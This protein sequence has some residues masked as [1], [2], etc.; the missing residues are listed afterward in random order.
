MQEPI[1]LMAERLSDVAA[2]LIAILA[3]SL[4]V[5]ETIYLVVASFY[6]A[7]RL[8]APRQRETSR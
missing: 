8:T 1:F 5:L 4:L 7:A 2:L 6:L 3:A